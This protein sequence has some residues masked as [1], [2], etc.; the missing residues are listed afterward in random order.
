LHEAARNGAPADVI[1]PLY[2]L[3]EGVE[4]CAWQCYS[5]D[6]QKPLTL[7]VLSGNLETVWALLKLGAEP[8]VTDKH[9]KSLIQWWQV[10]ADTKYIILRVVDYWEWIKEIKDGS[11]IITERRTTL[12]MSKD[13]DAAI[14]TDVVE[15]GQVLTAAGEPELCEIAAPSVERQKL[16]NWTVVIPVHSPSEPSEVKFVRLL[17]IEA[18]AT[19]LPHTPSPSSYSNE[20]GDFSFL[21]PRHREHPQ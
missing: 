21:S 7:A 6:A 1:E 8:S 14:S 20:T 13:M 12:H 11:R 15:D 18:R 17:D 9:G 5:E 19:A 3:G 4:E 16:P 10:D 2:D